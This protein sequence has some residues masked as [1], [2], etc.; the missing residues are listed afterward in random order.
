MPMV[1]CVC[2]VCTGNGTLLGTLIIV[3]V[4]LSYSECC[5]FH[6]VRDVIAIVGNLNYLY[7]VIPRA[8]MISAANKLKASQRIEC[9]MEH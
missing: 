6:T 7:H 3:K 5:L 9:V 2:G 8:C 4:L 1:S